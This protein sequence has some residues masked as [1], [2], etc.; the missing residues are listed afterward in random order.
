MSSYS[1]ARPLAAV[2]IA[3]I[4]SL[5][6]GGVTAPPARADGNKTKPDVPHPVSAVAEAATDQFI[7]G[8]KE[9]AGPA[10]AAANDAASNAAAKSGVPSSRLRQTATGAQV[11]KTDRA[12]AP[13]EAEGFLAALRA[14]PNVAFAEPDSIMQPASVDPNDGLY[15]LQWNLWE[16]RAGLRAPGAWAANRGEG[17]VVAVVDTGILGHSE[18]DANVLPGYDMLSSA[19]EAKD[20]DGRDADPTDEGD[21]VSAGQCTGGDP[22]SNSSWH[23]THV[24]GTIAAVGNNGIGV[25]GVAPEARILPIRAMGP[26]GGYTSDIADSI[27]WAAGGVVTGA[28]VNPNPARVIN[29]SLGGISPCSATYQNAINFAYNSGAAVV[30]A[31]GNSNRPA[32]DSSP[33]NCQNVITVAASSRSG[34]R[35]QY[36][37]YGSAVDVTAPGGDMSRDSWDGIL[38]TSNF[39]TSTAAE[40]AYEF[41]QGTSMAAPHVA[42]VAALLVSELREVATPAVVEERLR[43]TARPLYWGCPSGCG[44]GLVDAAFALALQHDV[45][46]TAGTPSISGFASIGHA[47]TASPGSWTPRDISFRYQWARDGV[48]ITGATAA[49][50]TVTSADLGAQLTVTVTGT[51]LLAHSV[52]AVSEPTAP[53]VT[54]QL[55]GP[56]PNFGAFITPAK[57]LTVFPGTWEPAPV[58]LTYQWK[59]SGEPIPGA[60]GKTYEITLADPGHALSVEVTGAK[61]GYE[62]VKRTS[63]V[64]E[65]PPAQIIPIT[66]GVVPLPVTFEDHP[67]TELDSYTI[68]DMSGAVEYWINGS[69]VAPGTYPGAGTVT[70]AARATANYGISWGAVTKWSHT[71]LATPYAVTPSAVTFTDGDGTAEDTFTVPVV[72]GVEYLVDDE[73]FEA[74]TYSGSGTVTVTARAKTDYVLAEGATVEWSHTFKA[75][76]F[77]VSPAAVVFTD[78]N[79][80]AEDTYTIPVTDG[81]EY[82]VDG[83][84]V[85]G[86]T[87][88]GSGVVTVSAR[89]KTDYVLAAGAADEWSHT[90]KATPYVVTP[91][92]VVFTD[93]DGTAEDT[94]TVPVTDGVDYLVGET[95][96]AA[97][98]YPGT[99]TVTVTASAKT[100]YVLVTSAAAE[101]SH[102]FMATPYPVTPA[103]VVFTD[104]D[105]T[106]EDTYTI[107]VTEGVDYLVGETVVAAGTYPGSGTVTVT[108]RAKTDYALAAG[109]VTE[110]VA[111]FKTTS[112]A[113]EPPAQSPFSDVSIGLP[114]YKEIN[115]LAERKISTGWLEAD[116]SRT[117]RPQES[118]SREA[119]AAFLYRMAAP[120]N[121]TAPVVSPFADVITGQLF[122]TEVAWLAE[123][124]IS[125]GWLETGGSRTYRPLESNSREAMA[126]FLYR[127]AGSPE[128]T[129]PSVSP[130][131]D[132][133]TGQVFY[134]EIA[135]LA[136]KRISTGW[137]EAGGAKSYRPLEPI[138]RDA[139]AAFLFRLDGL[140]H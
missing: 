29:L 95:V 86:G 73:I 98:T 90:F 129:A 54:S 75:T 110:W 105:G 89:A 13:R 132:V 135:W 109:S 85:A 119:M 106:A 125:T 11:V 15:S 37:N 140:A 113:Y 52:T 124:K 107:P 4:A 65:V 41:Q 97:G 87:H 101:W 133:A 10:A 71:F 46:T 114:F 21:W 68:P 16:D 81:A 116:G 139:M 27:V 117:Y 59:R 76:P 127:M 126:A 138:N 33:A 62:A 82:L 96:V 5:L 55:H 42:G 111:T 2:G 49:K 104:K 51:R 79:G 67:G 128:Y 12:L 6:I 103:A 134:K 50:Y 69:V 60:T 36:S 7:V 39:G 94:Y 28:P 66:I 112:S 31:A 24:A 8:I 136:E 40:E 108:S 23:G 22:A 19:S 47:L 48:D 9:K 38:S 78:R 92:A 58:T 18:L 118:V 131:I 35:A 84:V 43:A 99:G 74:G 102:T 14:D 72:D 20:G 56:V 70:V 17:V 1:R 44:A 122:Y 61:A 3:A 45:P 88:P 77:Q 123:K 93:K 100:D 32:A 25:T 34:A 53:V 115:W 80:S 130:F 64:Y 137:D 120:R 83:K 26:C 57:S 30:V 63:V 121:Y 91:A